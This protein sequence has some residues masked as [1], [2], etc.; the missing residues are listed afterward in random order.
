MLI[1]KGDRKDE[2]SK[3]YNAVLKSLYLHT[4]FF[5]FIFIGY[6]LYLYFKCYPLSRFLSLLDTLSHPLS[7]CFYEGIP[8]PTHP[9]PPSHPQFP[10]PGASVE[11]S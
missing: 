10:Y 9:L 7:H 1:V 3:Y 6:F 4:S 2:I 5:I 8:P 11:P